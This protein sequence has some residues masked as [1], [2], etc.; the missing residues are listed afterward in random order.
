MA[1][2]ENGPRKKTTFEKVTMFVV[3]LMVLVT[4]G[5]LIVSALSVLM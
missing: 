4:V 2:G 3:I 5:G 1:F